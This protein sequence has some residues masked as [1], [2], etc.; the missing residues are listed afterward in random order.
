MPPLFLRGMLTGQALVDESFDC[1]PG[2][3]HTPAVPE[4]SQLT[5]SHVAL[6]R[7]SRAAQHLA[8]LVGRE[9]AWRRH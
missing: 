4:R 5:V 7:L 8:G 2:N 9:Q 1:G 6:D 3:E